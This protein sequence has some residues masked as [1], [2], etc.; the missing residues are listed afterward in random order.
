MLIILFTTL[1]FISS[2]R[3]LQ[4]LLVLFDPYQSMQKVH[5]ARIMIVPL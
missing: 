4:E 3:T 5:V 2:N 1:T